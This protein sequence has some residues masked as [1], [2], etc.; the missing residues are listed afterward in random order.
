[1]VS[2][3]RAKEI[4]LSLFFNGWPEEKFKAVANQYSL[5]RLPNL[6]K[7]TAL[8]RIK[9]HKEQ[10]HEVAVVSAS[11]RYW[12]EPWCKLQDIDLL[13]SEL[14]IIDSKITGKLCSKNCHGNEKVI[15]IKNKYDLNNCSYIYAYGDSIGDIPMLNIA[16]EKFYRTF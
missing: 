3:V 8:K 1:L 13:A 12:L 4:L 2:N 9:W 11:S 10:N 15:R 6:V 5:S 16:N 7:S 14:E